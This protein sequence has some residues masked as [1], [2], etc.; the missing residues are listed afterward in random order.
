MTGQGPDHPYEQTQ[1]FTTKS[2]QLLTVLRPHGVAKRDRTSGFNKQ[3]LN[4]QTEVRL[5]QVQRYRSVCGALAGFFDRAALSHL[6][7]VA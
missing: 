2:A 5:D 7:A 6:Y 1:H 4:G 3:E